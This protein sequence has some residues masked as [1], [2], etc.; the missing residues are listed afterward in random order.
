MKKIFLLSLIL[1][2]LHY[3]VFALE[4][5]DSYWTVPPSKVPVLNGASFDVYFTDRKWPN[6]K[7]D[8]Y[9]DW[10]FEDTDGQWVLSQWLQDHG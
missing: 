5:G 4:W 1:L 7:Y 10:T 3:A 9:K 6:I 8:V 2:S